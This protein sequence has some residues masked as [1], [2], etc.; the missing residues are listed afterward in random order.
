L[1]QL[2]IYPE[3]RKCSRPTTDQLLRLLRL[4]EQHSPLRRGRIVD[5]FRVELTS[6]Q[7]RIPDLL[8]VPEAVCR[9]AS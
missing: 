4:V 5:T 7:R 9:P 2:P 8:A 3:D 6:L 1:H